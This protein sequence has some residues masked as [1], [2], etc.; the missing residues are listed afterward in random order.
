MRAPFLSAVFLWA[1]AIY[2]GALATTSDEQRPSSTEDSA[3]HAHSHTSGEV[4]S[5]ENLGEVHFN[6]SCGAGS[7]ALFDRAMALLHSF[8]YD[9]AR[10]AF[11]QIT[12]SDT[13]CAM[14]YWGVA[15][16]HLQ[17]LWAPPGA[18]ALEAG[19]LAAEKARSIGAAPP[20]E[21]GF[22]HA[23]HA[24]YAMAPKAGH[25]EAMI[26]YEQAMAKLHTAFPE[27]VEV[28][29]LYG[30]AL[31]AT[32]D[33]NDRT[34]KNPLRAGRIM[35]PFVARAPKHPG[36][37][38]YII[39]AYDNFELAHLALDAAKKYSVIAPSSAHALHMPSH[40]F[41]RLGL[42]RESIEMN[43]RSTQA[44]RDYAARAR[45]PG[46]WDEE[47]HGLDF[48]LTAYLQLGDYAEAQRVRDYIGSIET[49]YPE[50]FK[51]AY[52]FAAAPARYALERKDWTSAAGLRLGHADFPWDQFPWERSIHTFAVG[53]GKS[54][55]GDI[56]GAEKCRTELIE[57]ARRLGARN[58]LYKAQRLEI[59]ARILEAWIKLARR[60]KDGAVSAMRSAVELES[61]M[62]IPDGVIVPAAEILGDLYL[63]LKQHKSAIEA[64]E[65]SRQ[66]RRRGA[67][68]GML[69]AALA[70]QDRERATRYQA[71]MAIIS[72]VQP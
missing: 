2:A 36:L 3:E 19:R 68:T 58:L 56:E 33:P 64:Y 54:R 8:E 21:S 72:S 46:H 53:Y 65:S 17:P 11:Q 69:Q 42:W 40:I 25:R 1:T 24:Y 16:S 14:A 70:L 60:D 52:V 45:L 39:H 5:G 41:E 15:M 4:A 37:M 29:A 44:A 22:L 47:V 43:R 71:I 50:N 51:V 20:R 55:T 66:K 63:E 7:S 57:E 30:V 49:V 23:I 38:H 10:A 31:I 18:Q 34:F 48:M 13:D 12:D 6:V 35:E 61:T 27:D 26:A 32:A 9:A 59:H 28:A 67:V 62:I